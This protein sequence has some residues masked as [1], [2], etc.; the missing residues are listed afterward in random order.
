MRS[1]T[2]CLRLDPR[3]AEASLLLGRIF[4]QQAKPGKA[5]K[6]YEKALRYSPEYAPVQTALAALA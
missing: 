5:R 1:L 2:E 6:L 4:E 3:Q